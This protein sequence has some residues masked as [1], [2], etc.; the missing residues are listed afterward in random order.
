MMN[1]ILNIEKL[2]E[3]KDKGIISEVE[4]V[5]Q[6]QAIFNKAIRKTDDSYK[7]KNGIIYILLA[8]FLGVTGIHN[9]YARYFWRGGIQLFLSLTSFL[10]MYLTLIVVAVWALLELLLVGKDAAGVKFKGNKKVIILLRIVA[11]V[12][13]VAAYMFSDT[14]I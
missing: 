13:L 14:M 4:F 6:K 3:L 1:E 12:W 11:V 8:W 9:F 2:S 5:R 10:F 7:A